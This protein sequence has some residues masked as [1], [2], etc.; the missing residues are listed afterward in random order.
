MLN[1][2]ASYLDNKINTIP[3][4]WRGPLVDVLDTTD[5]VFNTCQQIGITDQTVIFQLVELVVGLKVN[6]YYTAQTH[7]SDLTES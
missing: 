2:E 4:E 5:V 1:L 6:N 3:K 7:D